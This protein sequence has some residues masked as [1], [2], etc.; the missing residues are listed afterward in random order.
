MKRTRI[1]LVVLALV[2]LVGL[3]TTRVQ[4][5]MPD[6]E[7]Y[8]TAAA[9]AAAA[10]PLY[11]AEDGH[12]Q[13]KYLPAFA[14]IASPI[15]LMPVAGAKAVWFGVSAVL[16]LALLW[17]SLRALPA[18]HRPPALLLA[19]TFVAMAK[20]YAHELVLGQVNL[21]FGVLVVLAIVWMRRGRD[22]GA[23]VLFALAVV[24]KPYG[25]IF[26]PWLAAGRRMTALAAMLIALGLLLLL[27]AIRYGWTGN[28]HLLASWWQTVT[29][30][31][32]PNLANPD[33]VSL[34][35]LFAKYLGQGSSAAVLAAGTG[36]VLLAVTGVV[37]GGGGRL[38]APEA[39]EG[40]LLLLLIPLLSPQGWDYVLLISTPAVMLLLD[41]LTSLPRGLGYATGAAIAIVAFAIYDL[42][43][44]DAYAAFMQLS[45]VTICAVIE[46]AA[47]V[48][49]RFRRVI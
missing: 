42:I 4:R 15:A 2:S 13:F 10:Q 47:L 5:K 25:A 11:R 8:Y 31:T 36:L 29:A 21:L 30:T 35:S 44:R 49:L 7:V 38:A 24:V 17:L 14:V 37:I 19:G 34:A 12:F 33:N 23:G 28:L 39:L 48:T 32:A 45:I 20:F 43:G 9:R 26:A 46:A 1:L 40:S 16:M 18:V 41:N 6:F 3:F 22:A 27:P